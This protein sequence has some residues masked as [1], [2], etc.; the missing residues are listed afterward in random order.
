V[1]KWRDRSLNADALV[2]LVSDS[3]GATRMEMKALREDTD[4]SFDFHHLNLVRVAD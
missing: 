4:F 1:S 3:G 2:R